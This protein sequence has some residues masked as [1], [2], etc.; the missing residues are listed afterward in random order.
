MADTE[1]KAI[2]DRYARRLFTEPHYFHPAGYFVDN[3]CFD[4]SYNGISL[5][6]GTWAALMSDWDFARQ[7]L[8]RAYRLRAHLSFPAPDGSFSGPSQMSSRTSADPPH[9][10][11]Q[12]P[13]RHPAA[14]MISDDALYLSPLPTTA[15]MQA[16]PAFIAAVLNQQLT[17]A[18]PAEAQPWRETHWSNAIN[19]AHEHYRKGY[20]ARRL[21]LQSRN[22]SLLKPLYQRDETFVRAFDNA[23]V[24]ARFPRWAVA[25]H[26]GPVGRAIGH[27]GRPFGYGGGQLSV[28]W[29]PSTGAVLAGR[30]RGV[31]GA[32]FDSNDE[33][34]EWPVHAVTGLTDGNELLTSARIERPE[35]ETKLGGRQAEVRVRGTI[36]KYNAARTEVAPSDLQYAR[37]FRIRPEGLE[38][39]TTLTGSGAE[40]LTELYESLP[41]FLREQA[42][43]K[44]ASIQ[45]RV[46]NA[47]QE[48]AAGTT[49]GVEAIRIR[50]YAGA[51]EVTFSRPR[52]VRIAPQPWLDGFQTRAECCTILV[53][54]LEGTSRDSAFRSASVQYTLRPAVMAAGIQAKRP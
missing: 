22:S 36:P 18:A 26:T 44:P 42:D 24:V 1:L 49:P 31:Q 10:Q 48:A 53:D 35:V 54:L 15:E 27:L 23:F 43:Q 11:W 6:F 3:V 33:W 28:F 8:D 5:Y 45:F 38:V 32:V 46:K 52:A 50:R 14:G 19:F 7:A 13:C 20:Y 34:R 39:K 21:Q 37:L 30:R 17:A 41:V 16:A 25:L 2:A 40:R 12:F 47:W 29:T 4:T 51:V 9:D